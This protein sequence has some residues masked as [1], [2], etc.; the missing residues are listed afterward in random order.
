MDREQFAA[1][2]VMHDLADGSIRNYTAMYVRW[3]DYAT[4]HGRDPMRPDALTVRAFAAQIHGTR[5]I[6]AHARSTIGHLCRALDVEDVSPAIPLPRQPR[7][8][9]NRALDH[10]VAVRLATHAARAG[11]K[12]TAVLVGM[13]TFAR[14]SE[15]ASLTWRNVKFEAGTITTMRPKSR[16]IHTV[17]LHPQLHDHLYARWV[18]GEQW[19]FPGRYG[20]HL[21]PARIREW[22]NEVAADAG[23]GHVTPH[24]L[25]HTSLTEAY[26]ASNDLRAVQ[27]LAGHTDPSVTAR[28]TRRTEQHMRA[29]VESLDY[30]HHEGA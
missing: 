15:I 4:A 5:S 9:S 1:Y 19:V 6:I 7:K 25:R 24:Q 18:P 27:E 21:S 23:C 3:C 16:D 8:P 17:P 26:D 2:L 14:V 28:Y 30:R 13:F 22:V 20:G 10:D 11:L 12:G 29:A